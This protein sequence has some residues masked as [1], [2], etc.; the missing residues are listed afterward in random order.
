MEP[1]MSRLTVSAQPSKEEALRDWTRRRLGSVAHELRVARVARMLFDL[2]RRRHGLSASDCRILVMGALVHDVGRS[3]GDKKHAKTGARLIL[4]SNSLPLSAAERRRVAYLAR[5]HKGN[6]PEIGEDGIL[7]PALDDPHTL[8]ILLGI[9]RAA[10]GLD[11]R[12]SGGL[13][14]VMTVRGS[15]TSRVLTIYGHAQSGTAAQVEEVYGRRKKFWL[16]EETL[17]CTVR[18]EWFGTEEMG[19]VG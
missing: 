2:T 4:E 18:T 14:L 6:A 19:L 9:L 13:K 15:R 3:L 17:D 8:H 10:D 1:A 12:Q 5:Y 16:L 7:D 11:S